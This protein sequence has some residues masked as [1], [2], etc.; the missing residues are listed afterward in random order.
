MVHRPRRFD[1]G[2]RPLRYHSIRGRKALDGTFTPNR[3]DAYYRQRDPGWHVRLMADAPFSKSKGI[4]AYSRGGGFAGSAVAAALDEYML[5][6]VPPCNETELSLIVA[7]RRRRPHLPNVTRE[8]CSAYFRGFD[9]MRSCSSAHERI[10]Q[11]SDRKLRI[12]LSLWSPIVPL[13]GS[14]VFAI[15][16]PSKQVLDRVWWLPRRT[17]GVHVRR[18]DFDRH[19]PRA[20][21]KEWFKAVHDT[22]SAQRLSYLFVASDDPDVH[23]QFE[24]EFRRI[25]KGDMVLPRFIATEFLPK[26]NTQMD[27]KRLWSNEGNIESLAEQVTL[28][29]ADYII[30]TWGSTYSTLAAAWFDKPLTY[31]PS[32]AWQ[33]CVNSTADYPCRWRGAATY[34]SP[35]HVYGSKCGQPLLDWVD[36]LRSKTNFGNKLNTRELTEA[37]R[38]PYRIPL[39]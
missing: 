12:G 24:Q 8:G 35:K 3:C 31:V 16:P 26:G 18:G 17:L 6:S 11:S 1:V 28:A 10:R 15:F 32:T 4:K 37:V 2:Y 5:G 38:Y 21:L 7:G 14:C 39:C 36:H 13:N 23:G 33:D 27:R 25:G 34:P 20:S 22:L 30:G 19:W 9:G 29:T